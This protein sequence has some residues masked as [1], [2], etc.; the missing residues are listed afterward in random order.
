MS[1]VERHTH[2]QV[3]FSG[4][5]ILIMQIACRLHHTPDVSGVEESKMGFFSTT[6]LKQL[7]LKEKK[8]SGLEN[9]D[10]KV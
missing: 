8:I 9:A 10:R 5:S 7:P 6:I 1:H 3:K 4:L 2:A